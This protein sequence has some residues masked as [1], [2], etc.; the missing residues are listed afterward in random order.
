MSETEVSAFNSVDAIGKES[1][2]T[3]ADDGFF[4]YGYFKTL[5][6][7]KT[8]KSKPI[9]L[10]VGQK[11]KPIAVAPCFFNPSQVFSLSSRIP[12]AQNITL[13]INRLGFNPNN[14]EA[15]HSPDSFHSKILI[16]KGY[17][18]K[19]ILFLVCK[20]IDDICKREK[21][22]FSSFP[23]VSEFDRI[24]MENLGGFGYVKYPSATTYY[25]DIEW[26]NFDDYVDSLGS[27]KI[28]KNVRREI[29]KCE[30]SG[31]SI[32]EEDEFGDI[33]T[34][35]SDL[36]S[37]LFSRYNRGIENPRGSSFFRLLSEHAKDRTRVFVARQ[38]GKIVG[39]SLFFQH[40]GILDV[41]VCGFDY[42]SQTKTDFTYFNLIY[43]APIRLAIQEEMTRIHFSINSD[44]LKLRR[45]C[46]SEK[47]Y[48]FVKCHNK[49]LGLLYNL[50]VKRKR[51]Y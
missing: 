1:M 5:E 30:E 34:T 45:G 6:R 9:Y 3:I 8:I 2:D 40:K 14:I 43:Y 13:A 49:L 32:V 21:I 36:H 41:S 29:R 46:K 15:C 35:L 16:K 4:T 31:V 33:S 17:S 51:V 11:G 10:V 26:S 24:L 39:F 18:E 28:K 44:L 47:M 19:R 12:I 7:M 37:N 27:Y 50:Y 20:K 25:L 42:N 22:L 48:S 23:Y 38:H